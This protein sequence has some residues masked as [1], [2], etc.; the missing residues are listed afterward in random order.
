MDCL[1]VECREALTDA[2]SAV[3]N[4]AI[5]LSRGGGLTIHPCREAVDAINTALENCPELSETSKVRLR[6]A[7]RIMAEC[8]SYFEMDYP[9]D[10]RFCSYVDR[11]AR[12][13]DF[14]LNENPVAVQNAAVAA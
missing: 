4:L 5:Q 7:R 10:N 9:I 14:V 8:V 2:K 13:V 1:T 3:H 11:G 6:N 12:E